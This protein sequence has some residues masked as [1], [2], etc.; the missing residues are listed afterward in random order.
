M[1]VVSGRGSFGACFLSRALRRSW[2][3]ARRPVQESS[4]K[5]RG[6]AFASWLVGAGADLAGYKG[7][8]KAAEAT[9]GWLAD[10]IHTEDTV[11]K[12]HAE[13]TEALGSQ[14][15]RFLIVIDDID[16]LSPDEALLIFRLVKS[17]G[18]LPNVIYLLVF[19]RELAEAIVSERFPSERG[20]TTSKKSFRLA[21]IFRSR[22]RPTSIRN[23]C[24]RLMRYA[25]LL[26]K[27]SSH[28]L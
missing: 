16:R 23:C 25:A 8:G 13:L 5:N 26:L 18:R 7:A 1:L 22:K 2:S 28:T 6:S 20:R 12:L 10:L 24:A 17:V 11:E 19:D 4:A 3:I 21:S 9:L 27:S 14:K 15:K